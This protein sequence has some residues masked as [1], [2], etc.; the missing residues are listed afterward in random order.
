M[1]KGQFAIFVDNKCRCANA[2]IIIIITLTYTQQ[3]KSLWQP[4]YGEI[5]Y[6]FSMFYNYNYK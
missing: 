4:L 3:L 5:I 2:S 1:E 6:I